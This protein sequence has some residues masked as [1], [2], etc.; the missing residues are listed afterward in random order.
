MSLPKYVQ[1]AFLLE[2]NLTPANMPEEQALQRGEYLASKIGLW[3]RK[4]YKSPIPPFNIPDDVIIPEAHIQLYEKYFNTEETKKWLGR[5]FYVLQSGNIP[6][7][8]LKL[9]DESDIAQIILRD[10]IPAFFN[11]LFSIKT[12]MLLPMKVPAIEPSP[13]QIEN[14]RIIIRSAGGARKKNRTRRKRQNKKK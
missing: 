13:I 10:D 1:N 7:W 9:N 6:A 12:E 8:P 5:A 14:G 11:W 3:L 2:L 4:G